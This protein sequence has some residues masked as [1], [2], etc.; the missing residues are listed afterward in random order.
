M[1]LTRDFQETF[2]ERFNSDQDFAVGMIC[3]AFS[4][5]M[6]GD[7]ETAR[8]L[9][10]DIVNARLRFEGLATATGT[11]AKSL[12]RMLGPDGNPSMDNLSAIFGAITQSANVDPSTLQFASNLAI[13]Q[14][15]NK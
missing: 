6:S 8:L 3:E 12:H 2:A 13:V 4:L 5:F 15:Q 14:Q 7:P 10:R 1:A 9:L 11:P